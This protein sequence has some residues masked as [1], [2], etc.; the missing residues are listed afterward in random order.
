MAP[1]NIG[2]F[3]GVYRQNDFY[4]GQMV[5]SEFA[6]F[7]D[8]QDLT[9]Q[10]ALDLGC[11]EGRYALFLA[12]RGCRVTA[13]DR[14]RTGLEK[15]A[16]TARA[17]KLP[18]TPHLADMADF[19]F[20]GRTW[21]IIVAATLLDHLEEPVRSRIVRDIRS[22]LKPGG[23]L[24]INVF[25]RDDPGYHRETGKCEKEP[26]AA[27]S[28]TAGCMAYYYD[29]RELVNLFADW[30]IHHYRETVEP[31][32]SH[33]RPHEHG[34]ANLIAEKPIPGNTPGAYPECSGNSFLP[35]T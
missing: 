17:E 33:G 32:H 34:W 27:V 18:V 11:G 6:D 20:S 28:D 31:D 13:V 7:V 14:S 12:R 25:T 21:D 8:R 29:R 24:Y 1:D 16:A 30:I 4:Y 35:R 9:S 15:L 19:D 2:T 23:F 10:S 5:R 22:A 3:N 26:P